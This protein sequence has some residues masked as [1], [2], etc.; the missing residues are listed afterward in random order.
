[1]TALKLLH[2]TLDNSIVEVVIALINLVDIRILLDGRGV[3]TEG[4]EHLGSCLLHKV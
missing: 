4:D 3:D 2:I 1:M